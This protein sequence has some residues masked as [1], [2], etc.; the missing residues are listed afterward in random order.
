MLG[1]SVILN[2]HCLFRMAVEFRFSERLNM[3]HGV[4]IA[5]LALG[6]T[7]GGC[8]ASDTGVPGNPAEVPPL[9]PPPSSKTARIMPLGD[10]ITE[11]AG[12]QASY[13]YYMWQLALD[14][15]YKIDFV[16]SQH[17]VFDGVPKFQ[18]FDMQHEGHWGW[19]TDQILAQIQDWAIHASPDF[20]LI[21]LGHND[22]RNGQDIPGTVKELGQ[23]IDQLRIVN[24]RI[25]IVLAQVSPTLSG[26]PQLPAFNAQLPALVAAK[27]LGTSP[28]VLVNQF[29]GFDPVTMTWDGS[30]PNALG[31]AQMADRWISALTPMLES[32][33]ASP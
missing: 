25:A 16:G 4:H 5:L 24:P 29:T 18:D 2:E 3:V 15:G 17:G 22:L 12:G 1:V 28:V 26:L 9:L 23:I 6:L 13:R 19:T 14:R 11:S 8:G 31:E 21:E 30:H 10:S 33:F 27:H 20:V 32:F 7:L